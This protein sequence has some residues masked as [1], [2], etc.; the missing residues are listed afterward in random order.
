MNSA[1]P[2]KTHAVESRAIDAQEQLCAVDV[3]ELYLIA[4]AAANQ[5]SGAIAAAGQKRTQRRESAI[6]GLVS[7]MNAN[8]AGANA[9]GEVRG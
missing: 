7:P 3:G 8:A 9:P 4:R 6:T 5:M 2:L 1:F